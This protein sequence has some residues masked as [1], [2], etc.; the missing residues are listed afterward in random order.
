MD[1]QQKRQGSTVTWFGMPFFRFEFL[2][3]LLAAA[4]RFSGLLTLSCFFSG[5]GL[6]PAITDFDLP[7][8]TFSALQSADFLGVERAFTLALSVFSPSL[9]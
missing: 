4:C 9:Q 8:C 7:L 5:T 3:N 2:T 1:S 6:L